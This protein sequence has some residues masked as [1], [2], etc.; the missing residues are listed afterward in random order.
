MF[1]K[2]ALVVATVVGSIFVFVA[3][4][5]EGKAAPE[6]EVPVIHDLVFDDS[7]IPVGSASN[8]DGSFAFE[9]PD[10]DIVSLQVQLRLPGGQAQELPP[11]ALPGVEGETEGT[12]IFLLAINPPMAGEYFFDVDVRDASGHYSESLNGMVRAVAP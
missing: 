11:S 10:G 3:C 6:G 8:I 12:A 7:D 1:R 4:G 2:H 5:D 9:D